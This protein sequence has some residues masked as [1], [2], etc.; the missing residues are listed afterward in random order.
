[1][2]FGLRAAAAEYRLAFVP[3]VRERYFLAIRARSVE[4]P[5]V[6]ALIDALESP[7][8]AR[9]ARSLPGYRTTGAGSV[10]GLAGLREPAGRKMGAHST[11]MPS[12]R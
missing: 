3:L 6:A 12:P 8:F 11:P 5:V 2:G 10:T 7:S 1:V 9:L 4:T